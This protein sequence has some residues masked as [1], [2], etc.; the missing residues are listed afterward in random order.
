MY[1]QTQVIVGG[2]HRCCARPA[3]QPCPAAAEAPRG[4]AGWRRSGPPS[5]PVRAPRSPS[6][7]AGAAGA[8]AGSGAR[9]GCRAGWSTG[10]AAPLLRR[11]RDQ[12]AGLWGPPA[13]CVMY[14]GCRVL[15]S[16]LESNEDKTITVPGKHCAGTDV[17]PQKERRG[18]AVITA[19]RK[20]HVKVKNDN[21]NSISAKIRIKM[22]LHLSM[23]ICKKFSTVSN[24]YRNLFA[25]LRHRN[26]QGHARTEPEI[27]HH[28][29]P[30]RRSRL[31]SAA[32]A[33]AGRSRGPRPDS[34]R[35]CTAQ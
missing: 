6:E 8:S 30:A 5:P 17:S 26:K 11:W 7:R 22:L 1:S 21:E 34:R 31:T 13:V 33:A 23:L 4:R 12:P 27:V 3:C 16:R 28:H 10:L 2:Y 29:L 25:A 19:V 15:A 32:A 14:P 35:S 20:A 18:E 24:F 9:P